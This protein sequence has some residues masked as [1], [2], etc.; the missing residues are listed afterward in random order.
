MLN[1]I[2]SFLTSKKIAPYI[3]ITKIKF[4]ITRQSLNV[5]H[6]CLVL[7]FSAIHLLSLAQK[8]T[9]KF[10]NISVED[11][12][13]SYFVNCICQDSRG[14][15][16][17]GTK[18]GLNRYDGFNF[19]KYHSNSF[20]DNSLSH[21][22][23]T[24]LREDKNKNGLWV[25]TQKGLCYYSYKKEK[26]TCFL[27]DSTNTNSLC[28]NEISS[29]SSSDD[30]NIWIG[31]K[32]GLNCLAPCFDQE[33]GELDPKGSQFSFFNHNTEKPLSLSGNTIN[34]VFYDSNGSLWVTYQSGLIDLLHLNANG[35]H[36][37]SKLNYSDSPIYNIFEGHSGNIWL[38][39]LKA[40]LVK[41]EKDKGSF[42]N[43]WDENLKEKWIN[44]VCMGPKG[45]LW[46]GTYKDG[47]VEIKNNGPEK[48]KNLFTTYKNSPEDHLTLTDDWIR[49]LFLDA[50]GVLWAG[51]RRNGIVKISFHQ[52]FFN[53]Y[54]FDSKGSI[55]PDLQEVNTIIESHNKKIWVGTATGL[56]SYHR[57]SGE[58]IPH[59]KFE[60]GTLVS[61][62]S[63]FSLCEDMFNNLWIGTY[64]DGLYKYNLAR[65]EF[66]HF[67]KGSKNYLSS[68]EITCITPLKNGDLLIGTSKGGIDIINSGELNKKLPKIEPFLPGLLPKHDKFTYRRKVVFED[69][70]GIIWITTVLDGLYKYNPGDNTLKHYPY[71]EK[72]PQSISDD[73]IASICEG[74]NGVIW[75]ATDKGLNSFNTEK[76]LFTRYYTDQGLPD[77][78]IIGVE[79]DKN[80]DVW[81]LTR[82]WLTRLNPATGEIR[83][84]NYYHQVVTGL[85]SH[86]RICKTSDG[87]F[88][89]GTQQK[90]FFSFIPENIIDYPYSPPVVITDFKVSGSSLKIEGQKGKNT[91]NE[92]INHT[93]LIE[94]SHTQ[95]N[96]S[97]S[98]SA[99]SFINQHENQYACLLEGSQDSWLYLDKN[100]RS[101]NYFNLLP[102]T[103]TFKVKAANYDGV[104][105]D[106]YTSVKITVSPPWWRTWWAY[107]IYFTVLSILL[108]AF[109][110]YNLEWISLRN[111]LQLEKMEKTK[112][113]ELNQLRLRF[114]TN[115]SHEFRTPLSLLVG[116]LE[117][118]MDRGVS[119]QFIKRNL[120][121]MHGNAVR[122]LRLIN[123]LM[124][125]RKTENKEM[126]LRAEESDIID[127][128]KGITELFEGVSNQRNIKLK[129]ESN[130]GSLKVYFDKDK[131]DKV[132]FNLLSNAFKFT[133]DGGSIQ[134]NISQT[135]NKAYLTVEDN[136][137]GMEKQH[138]EKIF[139]CFYQ[140][141][142]HQYGTGIGLSLCKSFILLHHGE[143]DVDSEPGKGTTF[144]VKLPLGNAHLKKE[145]IVKGSDKYVL[146]SPSPLVKTASNLEGETPH[147]TAPLV[148]IVEDNTTLRNFIKESLEQHF[149]VIDAENGKVALELALNKQPSLII[150]DVMMPEMDGIELCKKVKSDDRLSHIPFILLTALSGVG[151][152]FTGY[153]SGADDYIPK[154]FNPQLL[155]LRSKNLIRTNKK[156]KKRFQKEV[157]LEP[158]DITI[159]STD[160]KL[161]EKA[162]RAIEKHLG[163]PEFTVE[164]MGAEIGISRVHL[165]RKIKSLTD[166][167]AVDFIRTVRMKQAAK[168]LQSKK[169]SI[170]E[171]AYAVGFSNPVSF[172]RSFKKHF[173]YAPSDYHPG[174]PNPED[175]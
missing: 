39:G 49:C 13:S 25:G 100:Q 138:L 50:S 36:K 77:N 102:G 11:G 150:S 18:D 27:S 38:V 62:E 30:G 171:V 157:H 4:L 28:N 160:E 142:Q 168:L 162:M 110:H 161:L 48:S 140:V 169:L 1:Y 158:K 56:F 75:I 143:I 148:L 173:G 22:Y 83:N 69:S 71:D 170:A 90:G 16:W 53:Y 125:F 175:G 95:N 108:Y 32:Q 29:I 166:Q 31:T 40:G 43:V 7:C 17:I 172:G 78:T 119:D 115:I 67:S 63:V 92:S 93:G 72:N 19:I 14:F 116:P 117:N 15:L 153:K 45:N 121:L 123:Q 41:Y 87:T 94:L 84:F 64:G 57:D 130:L 137:K 20:D 122:L 52:D 34:F 23:I 26:F 66:T 151:D 155:V 96:I 109:Y 33:T 111:N 118:I 9:L 164:K 91:L 59:N 144:T 73:H 47:L 12:L 128:A 55:I 76:E 65:N 2:L 126:K 167:T 147:K 149:I 112:M 132:L 129:L 127:F 135:G 141:E 104:W 68:N 60:N 74:N 113:E 54:S 6:F 139:D 24:A 97:F 37:V 114:F 152:V 82:K 136:G 61:P 156:L 79:T 99:L 3:A 134:V 80:G 154:P 106:K 86:N 101:I 42:T 105:N 159:A 165:N 58:I 8:T 145:E 120:M 98:F 35:L 146:D 89:V 46:L 10:E 70:K 51:T 131:L 5:K 81:A 107:V 163:D 21:N 124:D 174:H 44:A 133:P 85:F 103:Y 88:F